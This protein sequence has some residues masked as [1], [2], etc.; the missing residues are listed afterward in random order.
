MPTFIEL[1]PPTKSSKHNGIRWQPAANSPSTGILMVDNARGTTTY[2][3]NEFPT[4]W[5]GRGFRLVKLTAGTDPEA[6]SYDVFCSRGGQDHRCECKGFL[7]FSHCKHIAAVSALL[8][9]EYLWSRA[10]L[11]NREQDVSSTEAPF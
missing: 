5:D 8:D 6:E 10:D 3:V 9:N 1:L 7:R 4:P 11:V 2:A